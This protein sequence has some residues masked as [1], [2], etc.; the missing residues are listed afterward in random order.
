MFAREI[1]GKY[2]IFFLSFIQRKWRN[3]SFDNSIV[4]VNREEYHV[5]VKYQRNIIEEKY[6]VSSFFFF[7]FSKRRERKVN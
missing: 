4:R 6:D 5:R 7:S 2:V 3:R 1:I